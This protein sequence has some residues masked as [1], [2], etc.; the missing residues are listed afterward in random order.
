[1]SLG[2][3][4]PVVLMTGATR[5]VGLAIAAKFAQEGAA[6]VMLVKDHASEESKKVCEEL[7]TL[8]GSAVMFQCDIRNDSEIIES[9]DKVYQQYGRLDVCVLNASVVILSNTQDISLEAYDLMNSVNARSNFVIAKYAQK[10]LRYAESP[11]IIMIAPP[12]NLD[13]RWLGSYLAYTASRYLCSMQVVGLSEEFR[14]DNISVNALWPKT[15]INSK[16]FCNVIQG[17]YETQRYSRHPA[18][19]GDACWSLL[20]KNAMGLTGEFFID[21]EV[22]RDDGV[23]DFSKY[24]EYESEIC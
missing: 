10:Y 24:A 21:E 17:T 6:L 20:S 16:D 15:N 5:G 2:E 14:A 9:I 11:H 12:I 1:M 7:G 22:L 13:P 18:I 8:G 4:Q 23:E 3:S 19:M